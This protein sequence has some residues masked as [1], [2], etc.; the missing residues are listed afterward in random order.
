ML[1]TAVIN[2]GTRP[3]ALR[4]TFVRLI[5]SLVVSPF[6]ERDCSGRFPSA[7]CFSSTQ[8]VGQTHKAELFEEMISTY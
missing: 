2:G 3:Q 8:P 7:P 5:E 4:L 1:F 6:G